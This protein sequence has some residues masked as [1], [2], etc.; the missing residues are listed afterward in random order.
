MPKIKINEV[1]VTTSQ[2][3]TTTSGSPIAILGSA[4]KGPMNEPTTIN[5]YAQFLSVFGASAPQDYPFGYYAG[6]ECTFLGN[7]I[8]FT[9]IGSDAA[10]KAQAVST[11]A[12]GVYHNGSAYTTIGA[13]D[14]VFTFKAKYPG[15]YANGVSITYDVAITDAT[16]GD[17]TVTITVAKGGSVVATKTLSYLNGSELG[18]QDPNLGEV[19]GIE[20]IQNTTTASSKT[21]INCPYTATV[22][23]ST[24]F[25]AI[26]DATV[27][28]A[29][30][31]DGVDSAD[32]IISGIESACEKLQDSNIYTF[33]FICAPGISELENSS[34]VKAWQILSD[35]CCGTNYDT[36]KTF[37]NNDARLAIID[38]AV[39]TDSYEDIL[40]DLGVTSSQADAN[41]QLAIMYPWF[42]GSVVGESQVVDIPPSI[43]YLRDLCAIQSLG[44]PCEPVAGPVRG[45]VSNVKDVKEYLGSVKSE[46]VVNMGVNPISYH[47]SYG[48]FFD[49]NVVYNP[50]AVSKTYKQLSIRNTINYIKN[51][52][53]EICFS[54]SYALNIPVIRTQFQGRVTSLLDTMKSSSFIY[55]Y[56]VEILNDEADLA[57]GRISAVIKVFPTT[58]LEEFVISLEVV[59]SGELL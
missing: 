5:T 59:N 43:A 55:G 57:E 40:T 58:A 32:N 17:G 8:L 10:S 53:N 22:G 15:T 3:G 31:T 41:A 11:K 48:Y 29:G 35:L 2:A 24:T 6:K 12:A 26:E 27:S 25:T 44:Y 37:E 1:N 49:G 14:S 13:N 30:G 38:P 52:L 47:R 18:T 20:V 45:V 39:T 4:I 42:E 19:A 9:R 34:N 36:S 56:S 50:N 54:L 28:L 51:R 16:D 7:S 46:S 23:E 33:Q 21:Y